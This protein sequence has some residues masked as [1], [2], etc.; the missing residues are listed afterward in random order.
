MTR[1]AQFARSADAPFAFSVVRIFR[2]VS[3]QWTLTEALGEI[4]KTKPLFR[5]AE[6]NSRTCS[7][8]NG[9]GRALN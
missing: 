6:T 8:L 5:V 1:R 2:G 7:R 9:N 4:L 3:F